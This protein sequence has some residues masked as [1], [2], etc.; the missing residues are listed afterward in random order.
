MKTMSEKMEEN[1]EGAHRAA[2][3]HSKVE[4]TVAGRIRRSFSE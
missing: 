1:L 4:T 3:L 2:H